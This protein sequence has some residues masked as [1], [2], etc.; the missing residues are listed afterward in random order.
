M[1]LKKGKGNFNTQGGKRKGESRI[2]ADSG[3]LATREKNRLI[4][5]SMRGK[6][7]ENN[8]KRRPLRQ[9]PLVFGGKERDGSSSQSWEKKKENN[10]YI[11]GDRIWSRVELGG[12]DSAIAI[13]E[14][15]GKE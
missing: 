11:Q 10:Q 12:T 2:S 1:E 6:K 5:F 3:F 15:E 9:S 4:V 13:V 14:D 8:R 7:K